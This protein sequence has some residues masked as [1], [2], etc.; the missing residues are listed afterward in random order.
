MQMFGIATS[1]D[2]E[3]PFSDVVDLLGV[4]VDVSGPT[5]KSV[6]VGSK[7]R[8]TKDMLDVLTKN[9]DDRRVVV[10]DLPSVFGRLQFMESQLLGSSG[11]LAIA[12]IRKLERSSCKMV[13]LNEEE[14]EIFTLLKRRIESSPRTILTSE[15]EKPM[16]VFRMVRVCE[17]EGDAFVGSVGAVIFDPRNIEFA[18]AFGVHVPDVLL[19]EWRSAGKRHLIGPV[20]MYAV[21]LARSTWKAEVGG[22]RII[23]FVDHCG[24][25]SSCINGSSADKT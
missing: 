20:E 22:R 5:G 8:R 21:I 3:L 18:K 4:T 12:E 14:V 11:R 19:E 23:Y 16:I 15:E 13:S 24:V 25:M 10:A 1:A 2:K 6:K 9:V 17:I 7:Q